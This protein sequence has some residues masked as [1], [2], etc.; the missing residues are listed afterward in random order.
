MTRIDFHFN[1]PDRLEYASRLVRKIYRTGQKVVVFGDPKVVAELDRLLWTFS[2]LDFIPHVL[3]SDPLAGRTPVILCSEAFETPHAD[4][5]VNLSRQ[6]PPFFSRFERLVEV[7]TPDDE[8]R[9]GARDRWRFY[10]DRGYPLHS[11]DLGA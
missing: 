3:S 6:T 5:L 8:D 7:V 9:A 2:A 11:H 1:A 4:V 10:R